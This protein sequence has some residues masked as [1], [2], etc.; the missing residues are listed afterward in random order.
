MGRAR[1]RGGVRPPF[2]AGKVLAEACFSSYP[3]VVST[4]TLC[5]NGAKRQ[6]GPAA[7]RPCGPEGCDHGTHVAGIAAGASTTSRS[8]RGIARWPPRT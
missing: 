7:A 1:H 4:R 5:P 2:L 3:G 6:L 8:W